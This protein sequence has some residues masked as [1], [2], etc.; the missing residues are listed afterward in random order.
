MKFSPPYIYSGLYEQEE[1]ARAI[2][3]VIAVCRRVIADARRRQVYA[4]NYARLEVEAAQIAGYHSLAPLNI[5]TG[6]A[7]AQLRYLEAM[8]ARRKEPSLLESL[9]LGGIF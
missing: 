1:R 9:G 4:E 5:T 2:S 8:Y 3:A 7:A 6:Q